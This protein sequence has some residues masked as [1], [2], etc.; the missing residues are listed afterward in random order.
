MKES[1]LPEKH[2]STGLEG[3]DKVLLGLMPGDNVVWQVD[4]IEAYAE[5]VEP[6][7]RSAQS[8]GQKLTYFRFARHPFL[9]PEGIPCEVHTLSPEDGFEN[10]ITT[11]HEVIQANGES[12]FYI[13]DSLSEL[14]LECYSDRMV[15]NFFMLTCPYLLK[16]KAI[17]YFAV[18]RHYHSFHASGP[19]SETTQL[20][21]DVYHH[22]EKTY[23]YPRKVYGRFSSS[24]FMLHLRNQE[25]FQPISQSAIV[26][27]VLTSV[28]WPGMETPSFQ[29]GVWN[30]VFFQAEEIYES[31][32]KGECSPERGREVFQRLLR[33]AVSKDDR[34]L[35]LA[36]KYLTF[37]DLLCMRRRLIGTG[38]LGGKSVGM[39]LAR[40][41]L[42]SDDPAWAQRLEAH[43]SFYIASEVF[44]TY[45]IL[46][47][48]WWIRKEQRN[49][50]KVLE[51]TEEAR[52]RIL[53][54]QFPDYIIHRFENMLEYFGQS[55]IIVRSSSL[56]EDN[57]GNMFA[58]KY[59]SVFCTNQGTRE[60]RL[61]QLMDAIRIVYA[62]SMSQDALMYRAQHG[63]LDQ[64]EQMA[65]L[66][67]RVSGAQYGD[68]FYPQVAGVGYSFN[69]YVWTKSID[70][71]AGVVR[72]VF[73]LGTRAVSA[74]DDDYTRLAALN[75]PHLRPEC[76]PNEIRKYT[77]R[78]VDVLDLGALEMQTQLFEETLHESPG[79]PSDLF[80]VRDEDLERF[81]R[82]H[83]NPLG[84]TCLLSFDRLFS[85]TKLLEDLRRMLK[86]L[87]DAY[88]S[89]VDIEFTANFLNEKDYRINL[90]QCRPFQ[91][92][93]IG[94]VPTPVPDVSSE[95]VL[96]K[97]TGAVIGTSRSVRIERLIS[98]I[99]RVYG[100]LP[101]QDRYSIARLVGK[102]VH[103]NRDESQKRT[104]LMG[105]GRWGTTTPSLGV[106][107]CFAEISGVSA[108]CELVMM[109]DG[110]V[111]EVSLGTHFFSNLI[112]SDILYTAL[113]P[114]R[115]GSW[116]HHELLESLPN[117]LESL[118]PSEAR[119]AE[120]VRVTTFESGESREG[121]WLYADC[122]D[123]SVIC[124]LG[125][126]QPT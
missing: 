108:V 36:E 76:T 6:L 101:Q 12:G 3:L 117:E 24:I 63:V 121:L 49:P 33:M 19:I 123:Q 96:F 46:N 62:S 97:G 118:L 79:L 102:L 82:E 110:L 92:K 35:A 2:F 74:R 31:L 120:A 18:L 112:E 64:D 45:L 9:V 14:A 77:Q 65:L 48:C 124:F 51:N 11:I 69:P 59:E 39:L 13:F 88:G 126:P 34:I 111:P 10:F 44:Y 47:D 71:A 81:S 98:I 99:P 84:P 16:L 20:L 37:P 95:K 41:I 26:A 73:G 122:L 87:Q 22:H 66:V 80:C 5:F 25:S 42:L 43:D 27:E 38:F 67:Q 4:S 57:Y 40:A 61:E 29:V 78:R 1:I 85:E 125:K 104:L 94:A 58:G 115:E 105:P 32:K 55:P 70:P 109:R 21:I 83:G 53:Q 50:L 15:G 30:R 119:H 113:F 75:A 91:V 100:N 93:G 23:I 28:P 114:N 116:V 17:A 106:P 56:L 54:G 103:L 107:V 52:R 68:L 90:L 8:Q 89:P 86:T 60:Q 72:L 7:C